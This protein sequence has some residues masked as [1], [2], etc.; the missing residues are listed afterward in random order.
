MD[1]FIPNGKNMA[2]RTLY[3][4]ISKDFVQISGLRFRF[5]SIKFDYEINLKRLMLLY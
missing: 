3:K 1:K 5:P 4:P 2:I